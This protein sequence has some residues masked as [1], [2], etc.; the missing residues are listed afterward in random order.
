[1]KKLLIYFLISKIIFADDFANEVQSIISEIKTPRAEIEPQLLKN[2][3]NPFI[4]QEVLQD[5]Q[6]INDKSN[7]GQFNLQS[8]TQY[9]FRKIP[10]IGSFYA[11]KII[12]YRAKNGLDSIDDLKNVPYL[13]IYQIEA[14]KKY[15]EDNKCPVEVVKKQKRIIVKRKKYIPPLKLSIIFNQ[16][17]KIFNHW[18]KIGDKIR[19]YT[20]SKIS[21]NSVVL[22]KGNR[23]K[24][25]KIPKRRISKKILI[26][27]N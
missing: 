12:E 3:K 4:K 25:L 15:I 22:K 1:M 5:F 18:Y 24:V 21:E 7:C 26:G 11:K 2:L 10:T 27:I 16:R 14:I 23:R 20:I 8:A 13:Q 17:A 19:G 6:Q 9:D